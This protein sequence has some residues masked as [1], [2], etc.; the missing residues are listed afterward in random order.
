MRKAIFAAATLVALAISPISANA[1]N[2]LGGAIVG[3]ATGAAIGGAVGGGRGAA[4]GAAVGATTGAAVGANAEGGYYYRDRHYHHR[5]CWH[6]R[7]GE[8]RCRYY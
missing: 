8:V 3:G 1:Q 6:N 2:V 5:H 4:V 7:F